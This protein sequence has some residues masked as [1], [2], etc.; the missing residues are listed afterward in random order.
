M[1]PA[2]RYIVFLFVMAGVTYMTRLLPLLFIRKK[3]TNK[4][5]RSFLYYV[6]Y[7]VLTA[8]TFPALVTEA[9]G[10]IVSGAVAAVVCVVL[11][12]FRKPLFTVA[13]GGAVSVLLCEVVI[14]YVVPIL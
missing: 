2:Y 4:F 8:M 11:A 5:I 9:T 1:N 13:L 3:I 12:Y 7:A 10:S 6:P 14:R